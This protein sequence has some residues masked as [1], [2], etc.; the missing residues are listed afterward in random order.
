MDSE[1]ISL[2][3]ET[4]PSEG[5]FMERARRR[6][7]L[8]CLRCGKEYFSKPFVVMPRNDPPCPRKKCQVDAEVERRLADDERMRRVLDEQSPPGQIGDNPSVR[9]VD[10][11][12][13]AVMRDYGL[14]DLRDRMGPGETAAPKLPPQQQRAADNFFNGAEVSRRFGNQRVAARARALGHM[15]LANGGAAFKG[16]GARIDRIQAAQ[17]APGQP[18]LVARPTEEPFMVRMTPRKTGDM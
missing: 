15:A 7:K 17:G 10:W 14:T 4:A 5:G 8:R 18:A 13:E 16:T 12:A 6:L 1:S 2:G 9:A 3:T 11:T